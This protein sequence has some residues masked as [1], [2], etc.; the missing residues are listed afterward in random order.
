MRAVLVDLLQCT[1]MDASESACHHGQ[2]LLLATWLYQNVYGRTRRIT[3]TQLTC[4][5]WRQYPLPYERTDRFIPAPDW[6]AARVS[7]LQ[8][9]LQ[10]ATEADSEGGED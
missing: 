10:V 4:R 2:Q 8:D 6:M 1:D 3:F 5:Q 7:H 9:L